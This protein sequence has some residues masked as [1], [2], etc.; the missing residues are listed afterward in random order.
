MLGKFVS[1]KT[2]LT[3]IISLFTMIVVFAISVIDYFQL[4]QNIIT[5]KAMQYQMVNDQIIH[6]VKNVDLVYGVFE[7]DM[8]SQM[9]KALEE[10]TKKYQ[11]EPDLNNW[12]FGALKNS[13]NNMDIFVIDRSMKVAFSNVESDVGLDFSNAG[14]FTNLLK[15]RIDGNE[16]T[17]DGM[18]V[19]VTTG[20]IKKF[21]YLPTPDHQYLLEV[22]INLQDSSL[23]KA[24]NFLDVSEEILKK[25]DIVKEITVYSHDGYALGKQGENG[26]A[27]TLAEHLKPAFTEAYQTQEIREYTETVDGQELVHRFSP[28]RLDEKSSDL[29]RSRVIEIVFDNTELN[30]LLS[31]KLTGAVI[32][33][34]VAVAAA[35]AISFAISRL[36]TGPIVRMKHLVERTA[37]FDLRDGA[38]QKVQTQDEIGFMARSILTMREQLHEV[39]QK[40]V[41]ASHSLADNAQT[42]Q[43]STAQVSDQSKETAKAAQVLLKHVQETMATTEEMNATLN[44]IQAVI[45]SVS[46]QTAEAASAS[47]EVSSRAENMKQTAT[48]A[49]ETADQ[50]YQ[51]VKQQVETAIEQSTA[52]M[53]QIHLLVDAILNISQQTNLLALNA[54][55]EAARAGESGKGFSVVADEIRKLAT[56]SSNLVGNIQGVIE[57]ARESVDNLS[58]SSSKVLDFIDRKVQADYGS[59]IDISE[60]YDGDA[61]YFG[62]LLSEFSAA[63]EELN[64]SITNTVA[65][66][67]QITNSVSMNA[68]QIETI[69]KQSGFIADNNDQVAAISQKNADSAHILREVVER[70]KL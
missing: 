1:L 66:V 30:E 36:I 15:K 59:L 18:E 3:A 2:K 8:E 65:A 57:I 54:A 14:A 35:I 40:L 19:S 55:I 23:F 12:D 64:A 47:Q 4:K 21:A 44:D 33:I 56:Q 16:F 62:T 60:Q 26:K 20:A 34:S 9:R 68:E 48:A 6:S 28:Y 29:S 11:N 17:A 52:S 61:N 25:Y 69:S 67:E 27:L 38:S 49:R 43:T 37:Q 46:M 31:N 42:I 10:L 24:F 7:Q 5:E 51:E 13:L 22:G 53:E 32:K 50:I 58:S 45:Q 70:F 39:A 63:F 41:S